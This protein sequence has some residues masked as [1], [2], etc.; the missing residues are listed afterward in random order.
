MIMSLDNWQAQ[1]TAKGLSHNDTVRLL[2]D[3][4]KQIDAQKA[5]NE[6]LTTML[7]AYQRERAYLDET[8]KKLNTDNSRIVKDGERMILVIAEM[9]QAM[10]IHG[11]TPYLE[12]VVVKAVR[13]LTEE[14]DEL[15][16]ALRDVLESYDLLA[17]HAVDDIL[18]GKIDGF[19]WRGANNARRVLG[20]VKG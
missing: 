3:A 4:R 15:R 14:R 18:R 8:V 6:R 1:L 10:G 20:E 2:Q 17:T 11:S 9:A 7:D 5:D 13:Q 12:Q 16:A 19:S